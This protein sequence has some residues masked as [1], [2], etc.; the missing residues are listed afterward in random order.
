[1]TRPFTSSTS[2]ASPREALRALEVSVERLV[3]AGAELARGSAD[4]EAARAALAPLAA[5]APVVARIEALARRAGETAGVRAARALLEL[6]VR[7]GQVTFAA[8]PLLTITGERADLPATD[9]LTSPLRLAELTPLV[10]ALAGSAFGRRRASVL[11]E[12]MG[13]GTA[14]DLRLVPLAVAALA[15]RAIAPLVAEELLPSLGPAAALALRDAF[16]LVGA[17][18]DAHK[19]HAIARIEGV[20]AWPLLERALSLGSPTVRAAALRELAAVAPVAAEPLA[21]ARLAEDEVDDVK[22]A[23]VHALSAAT[24][25]ASLD[26]LLSAFTSAPRLRESAGRA[27][28]ASLH[29]EATAR[30][31]SLLTDDLAALSLPARPSLSR[32]IG[33]R[34]AHEKA[35]AAEERR[36][37]DAKLERLTAVLA[38]LGGRKDPRATAALLAVFREH[39]VP[40]ARDAAARA[41]LASGYAGAFDELAPAVYDADF[42]TRA[43]LIEH[44][45]EGAAR[46]PA[47]AFD[48]LGRFLDPTSFM[49]ERHVTFAAHLL[50][51]LAS[52]ALIAASRERDDEALE[53]EEDHCEEDEA[54]GPSPAEAGELSGPAARILVEDERWTLACVALL[55]HEELT[56]PALDVLATVRSAHAFEAVLTL[57]S[58]SIPTRHAFRMLEVLIRYPDAR[59]AATLPRFLDALRGYWG[60]RAAYRAMRAYDDPALVAPLVAWTSGRRRLERRERAEIEA[61]LRFL[62]RDRAPASS[63]RR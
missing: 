22:V 19:L 51:A 5:R 43:E 46:E 52:G 3:M 7:L 59:V 4:L 1:V 9:K 17:E 2:P 11:R 21:R 44:V 14:R 49:T 48:R 18:P 33:A 60:R 62:R 32:W 16:A 12:A 53:D 25:D 47:R 55:G 42:T 20:A 61:L 63:T 37:H 57:A 15:D 10:D 13:Q 24:S 50:D 26:A 8:A 23:A 41:L 40:K 36:A 39:A 54:D 28:A 6:A 58:R 38:L 30:I 34:A 35:R 29:P 31:L 27:L 45:F 56:S